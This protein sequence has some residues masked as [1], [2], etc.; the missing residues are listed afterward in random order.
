M[1]DLG[2]TTIFGDLIINGSIG[3]AVRVAY[4]KTTPGAV[5]TVAVYLDVDATGEEATV[6]CSITDGSALNAATPRLTDGD[7]IFVGKIN[8]TW[9]CLSLF[10]TT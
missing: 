6:T 9:Y 7:Q 2:P 8:D 3:G 5:S 10:Y 1:A 4:V